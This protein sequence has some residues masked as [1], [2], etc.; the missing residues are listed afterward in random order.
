MESMYICFSSY[1]QFFE[2][3]SLNEALALLNVLLQVSNA[4]V[5]KVL[6]VVGG[7]TDGED[8]LNT[9]GTKLNVGSEE[10]NTL[11]SVDR[12]LNEGGLNNTLLA[13]A[14]LE[15]AVSE[16]GTSE[17]HGESSRSSTVLGINK[18]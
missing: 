17:S 12:G 11:V 8:L 9:V 18:C 15:K 5:D 7:L 2:N 16:T 10:L 1:R 6:L 3:L 14:G 4:L 13:L